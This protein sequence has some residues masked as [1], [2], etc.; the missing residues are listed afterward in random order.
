MVSKTVHFLTMLVG[1][2]SI[3]AFVSAHH[4]RAMYDTGELISVEGV[5]ANVQWR[6]PHM[7]ITLD[8]PGSN[9]TT[10]SWGFEG[11][12]TAAMVASGISPQILKVGNRVKI[13]AHP[14]KDR[15]KRTAEFMGMEVNGKYYARGSGTNIRG[16][17]DR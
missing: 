5:V 13:I 6:N 3:E 15:S 4:S 17:E 8:V 16:S 14:P 10:E 11:S 7:W 12:G 1:F 9:G 2:V